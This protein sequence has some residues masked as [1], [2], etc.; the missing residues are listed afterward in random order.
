MLNLK[1]LP[2][3]DNSQPQYIEEA[4]KDVDKQN[5]FLAMKDVMIMIMMSRAF[6]LAARSLDIIVWVS[7]SSPLDII[8]NFILY[9]GV[10]SF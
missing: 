5:K 6:V 1:G 7:S 9:I 3:M 2:E 10:Y 8:I 4:M